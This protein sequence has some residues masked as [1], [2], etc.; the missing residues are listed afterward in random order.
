MRS[1]CRVLVAAA[2]AA[3][4]LPQLAT[5]GDI[6]EQMRLMNERMAQME[7][8]LQATKDELDASKD[9]VARQQELIQKAGLEREAQS[10][11]SKFLSETQFSGN[12][13]VS[14]GYNFNNPNEPL[15]TYPVCFTGPFPCTPVPAGGGNPAGTAPT[16]G[17]GN[18][19]TPTI[20][21]INGGALGLTAPYHSNHNTFQVD[22]FLISMLKP[23]TE[24]SRGG[25]AVD[26]AWGAS[27]D[28]LGLPGGSGDSSLASGDLPHLY[29]AYVNYL[30]PIGPGLDVGMGR[31]ATWVGAE[32][33]VADENWNVTRGLVF[34]LQP[35]NHTGIWG[36]MEF[37][38]GFYL[39]MAGVNGYSNT[40]KDFD[41]TKG[42]LGAIGWKGETLG[43]KL[44]GY[45]G[46]DIAEHPIFGGT[47]VTF[48]A[49]P[50][51]T[52]AGSDRDTIAMIDTVLSFT[53]SDRFSSWVNFDWYT[54]DNSDQPA[55]SSMRVYA[56]AAAGRFAVTEALGF[57]LRYEFVYVEDHPLVF[58]PVG[59]FPGGSFTQDGQGMSLT[60][61]FDYAL[62][63]NL[64]VKVEGRY[65]WAG[66]QESP[67]NFFTSSDIGAG[68]IDYLTKEDQFLGI[69]QM[70]YSF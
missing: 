14:W 19:V 28:A 42:F 41:N 68:D 60:G 24:E 22:Q 65:D 50:F 15:Q 39:K 45:Y 27:A 31:F 1:T 64:T 38:N 51:I 9:E 66:S 13:A 26:L 21:G 20:G 6:E 67:D 35:V 4:A 63:D 58:S 7:G 17:F 36:A 43:L 55:V 5:A 16:N 23:A 69:L 33:F 59:P 25:F 3:L 47:F 53:P 62:T 18:L 30:A 54:T 34:A 52:S 49:D 61:T 37:E 11:L 44:A 29:Q 8:Q 40:M 46:G 2:V 32:S 70:L 48:S 57:S 12:V 10:G 56:L